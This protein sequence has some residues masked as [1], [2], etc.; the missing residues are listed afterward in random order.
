M[1]I[2]VQFSLRPYFNEQITGQFS[3]PDI[4]LPGNGLAD[5]KKAELPYGTEKF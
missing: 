2:G 4:P 5:I 3:G 1:A